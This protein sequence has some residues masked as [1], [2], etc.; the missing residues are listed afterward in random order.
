MG[1]LALYIFFTLIYLGLSTGLTS[2]KER[3][4]IEGEYSFKQIHPEFY[5]MSVI[6]VDFFEAGFMVKS[7]YHKYKIFV[8]F[9]TSIFTTL[10]VSKTFF[11]KNLPFLGMSLYRR[12]YQGYEE[13]S[14]LPPG[15][16]FI[17]DPS[18]GQWVYRNSGKRVWRFARSYRHF[19]QEFRWGNFSP[20]FGFFE[21][22][23]EY[24]QQE[25]PFLGLENEFG[26][27]G[28]VT[29]ESY[30]SFY[31]KTDRGRLEFEYHLKQLLKKYIS[32]N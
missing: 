29:K 8:P 28:T 23:T 30:Q 27:E 4:F 21:M 31:H 15:S 26:T 5:P 25:K 9:K 18:Y 20:D 7:Y 11:H 19:P 1:R 2:N 22:Q 6:L 32:W 13:F 12:D 10:R 24:A 14:P 17:G 3:R 16:L